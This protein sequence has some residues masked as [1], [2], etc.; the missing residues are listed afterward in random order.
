MC[1]YLTPKE[2]LEATWCINCKEAIAIPTYQALPDTTTET[3][4]RD[5]RTRWEVDAAKRWILVCIGTRYCHP[6]E[7]KSVKTHIMNERNDY[8]SVD[9]PRR[10]TTRHPTYISDVIGVAELQ[11]CRDLSGISSSVRI[12]TVNSVT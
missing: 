6:E 3:N 9:P 10:H 4:L 7:V 11:L 5:G 2:R 12:P 8:S 1:N